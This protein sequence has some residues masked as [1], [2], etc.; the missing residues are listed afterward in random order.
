VYTYGGVLNLRKF[1]VFGGHS[2]AGREN[3]SLIMAKKKTVVV[4]GPFSEGR[5]PERQD[6]KTILSRRLNQKGRI[7][8]LSIGR[9]ASGDP[10]ERVE[11]VP[12]KASIFTKK[13]R[14]ITARKKKPVRG[15]DL[16]HAE[17]GTSLMRTLRQKA[18]REK[19]QWG[20]P[21]TWGGG[22]GAKGKRGR[23]TGDFLR[24]QVVKGG[25]ASCVSLGGWEPGIKT[26]GDQRNGPKEGIRCCLKFEGADVPRDLAKKNLPAHFKRG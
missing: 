18:C 11:S 1:F 22:K 19:K 25:E 12:R 4:P 20:V 3:V 14:N 24:N 13:A 7:H 9:E 23:S 15:K 6:P 17:E 5:G 10:V 2:P 21:Y 26:K 16:H 8:S